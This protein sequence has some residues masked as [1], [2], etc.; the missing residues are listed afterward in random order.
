M[1]NPIF[2]P[3]GLYKHVSGNEIYLCLKV[4]ETRART[5]TVLIM[6]EKDCLIWEIYLPGKT[7]KEVKC[8]K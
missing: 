8:Q 2:K 4:L 3:G 6:Y 1:T 5:Q 7:W